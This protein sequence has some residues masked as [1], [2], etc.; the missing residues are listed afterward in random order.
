MAMAAD[1]ALLGCSVRLYEVAD[2][3]ANLDPIREEGGITLTGNPYSGETGLASLDRITDDPQR[4]IEDSELILINVPA[5]VVDKFVQGLSPYFSAGQTVVVT[6]GYWA[7]LRFRELLTQNRTFAELNFAEFSIMPY[8]SEKTG[9][10]QVHI[11]NYKRELHMSAWPA[12]RN[13][14]AYSVVKGVYP[15]VRLT[16]N[17]LELNFQPGNPGV[18]PQVVIPNAAF[19]FERARVFRFYAEVSECASRLA[20]AYDVERMRVAAA[21]DCETIS[22][23]EYCRRVY[24]YEGKDLYDLCA[25]STGPHQQSWSSIETTERLLVEDLCYSLAPMEALAKVV[26]VEVPITTAIIDILAVFTGYD[27]R[28]NGLT[29]KDLGLQALSREQIISF[30]TF[31][32]P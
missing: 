16:R 17:V 20:D 1:L 26:G 27:Y 10:A 12:T 3:K 22:W 15:Q 7:A 18:H 9:P 11:S 31:G 24:E 2:L 28:A 19:F 8:L 32:H 29:L 13:D 30:V 25:N 21:F 4:A 5:T 23:P 6:T 14:A